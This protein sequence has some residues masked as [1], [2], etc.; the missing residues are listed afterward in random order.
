MKITFRIGFIALIALA[1][2]ACIA[3]Q[4]DPVAPIVNILPSSYTT[5]TQFDTARQG[6]TVVLKFTTRA[7]AEIESFVVEQYLDTLK[8]IVRGFPKTSGF[9]QNKFYTDSIRV[10]VPVTNKIITFRFKTTDKKGREA[11][12]DFRM[13]VTGPP[14][15][16]IAQTNTALSG[17][18][19]LTGTIGYGQTITLRVNA[20]SWVRLSSFNASYG[21]GSQY[22]PLTGFPINNTGDTSNLSTFVNYTIPMTAV[23]PV[24]LLLQATDRFGVTTAQLISLNLDPESGLRK[25][26]GIV[27]YTDSATSADQQPGG[28]TLGSLFS[29]STGL[30]TAAS[31]GTANA[32]ISLVHGGG[33]IYICT[34]VAR[35]LFS[36]GLVN[37]ISATG[38]VFDSTTAA[39]SSF[40]RLTL[41]SAPLMFA[42]PGQTP[43]VNEVLVFRTIN[44]KH[45]AMRITEI[46]PNKRW[47]KFDIRV[48]E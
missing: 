23:S 41:P 43:Q 17:S 34:P 35:G 29:S 31:A 5:N 12:K 14:V 1:L 22:L 37:N 26:N 44:G 24:R 33:G 38:N 46:A 45:G 39:F 36:Q 27:L 8:T 20:G 6:R 21:V 13:R 3:E 9:I 10:T 40:N 30:V 42:R 47:I 32:D 4:P 19:T 28:G 16:N 15:I 7:D 2:K 11:Y 48:E 18:T 25:L